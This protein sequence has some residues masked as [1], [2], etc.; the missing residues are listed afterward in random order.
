MDISKQMFKSLQNQFLFDII[1]VDDLEYQKI[2]NELIDI[3]SQI[4]HVMKSSVP[5]NEAKD[6]MTNYSNVQSKMSDYIEYRFFQ[7]YFYLG[8]KLGQQIH[9]HEVDI[10]KLIQVLKE[11]L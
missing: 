5:S 4:L 9:D 3:E 7:F 2:N 8:I 6:M 1:N 10:D 11:N